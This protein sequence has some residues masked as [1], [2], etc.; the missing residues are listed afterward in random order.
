MINKQHDNQHSERDPLSKVGNLIGQQTQKL[1]KRIGARIGRKLFQKL[2]L[3]SASLVKSILI[4]TSV[5][6]APILLL[7]MVGVLAFLLIYAIPRAVA[8]DSIGEQADKIKSFFGFSQVDQDQYSGDDVFKDYED[9]A[10]TWDE[11]LNDNQRSQAA[12]YAMS[13]GVL[14]GVDRMRNDPLMK[15]KG[16]IVMHVGDNEINVEGVFPPRPFIP[17]YLQ[18]AKKYKVDWEVLSAIHHIESTYSTY[19]VGNESAVG[20][21]GPMMF[22]PC[23]WFGWSHSTCGGKG[24]GNIPSSE[25]SNPNLIRK[26]GGYGVDG[27]GD[28]KADI[29]NNIDAI[30]SAA[31]YLS[32]NGYRRDKY[33]AILAYNHADWYVQKVLATAEQIHQMFGIKKEEGEVEEYDLD[34]MDITDFEFFDLVNDYDNLITPDPYGIMEI[35]RPEFEWE[36]ETR[37]H[38]WEERVCKTKKTEDGGT[39][40]VCRWVDKKKEEKTEIL[41]AA[42]TY[43]GTYTHSYTIQT[44]SLSEGKYGSGS[45]RNY[46]VTEPVTTG[47]EPPTEEEYMQPLFDQLTQFGITEQLDID[48]VL[49]LMDMYDEKYAS[50]QDDLQGLY[51]GNYPVIEGSNNWRWPAVSKRVTSRYGP[52][53]CTGCS[54]FHRGVDVGGL[55]P[56]VDGDPIF[57]MEDG[58]VEIATYHS[59][60]GNYVR[61]GHGNNL[62]SR[63]L[64]LSQIGVKSGQK[65]KKGDVIGTMGNTGNS[66]ATHLHFEIIIDGVKRDP[67]HYY[68]TIN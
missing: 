23:T 24:K 52:R 57:A 17:I 22:M 38:T 20:A 7:F 13:W 60:A 40:K 51:P 6:W 56:G 12:P 1:G 15:E 67:L 16:T 25:L 66:R 26:N 5:M 39:K 58:V 37:I 68:P 11:G 50:L 44:R 47:V 29:M 19:P 33:K 65:V 8:E 48:L 9:A 43:E 59:A 62:Q 14:A 18:A 27:N 32:K 61:I 10:A 49:E 63:Y 55:T 46:K 36:E 3:S 28:G 31:K 53:S 54:K 21:K 41:T 64:H 45:V 4:K 35:L 42:H 34:G 30:H 2:L